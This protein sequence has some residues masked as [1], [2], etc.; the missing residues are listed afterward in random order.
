MSLITLYLTFILLLS[1]STHTTPFDLSKSFLDAAVYYLDQSYTGTS[2][3]SLEK[4][5][6]TLNDA[7]TT[8]GGGVFELVLLGDQVSVAL[9]ISVPAKSDFTL[10]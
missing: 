5:F 9:P 8:L 4:P 3:G 10:R 6:K 2:D 7:F 1:T